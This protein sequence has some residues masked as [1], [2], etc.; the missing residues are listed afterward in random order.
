MYYIVSEVNSSKTQLFH[1]K[2][3]CGRYLSYHC[4]MQSHSCEYCICSCFKCLSSS[5]PVASIKSKVPHIGSEHS[6]SGSAVVNPSSGAYDNGPATI[7]AVTAEVNVT[8]EVVEDVSTDDDGPAINAASAEFGGV[9]ADDNDPAVNTNRVE[10]GGVTADDG[11]P[12]V[13]TVRAEVGGVT[14]DDGDPTVNTVR[15]EVGGVIADDGDPSINDKVLSSTIAKTNTEVK[16]VTKLMEKCSPNL[17]GVQQADKH[18]F[19]FENV[20]P[21]DLWYQDIT[22]IETMLGCLPDDNR[23]L[24]V[25]VFDCCNDKPFCVLFWNDPDDFKHWLIEIVQQEAYAQ[26]NSTG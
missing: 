24:I 11:D 6:T 21:C 7:K 9:T 4:H 12:T 25:H 26:M 3:D 18:K 13:N 14:A 5:Q 20:G 22:L 16:R 23:E 17:P 1:C 10:V 15:V 19:Y 2:Q 8:G